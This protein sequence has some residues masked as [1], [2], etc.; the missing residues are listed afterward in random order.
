[1]LNELGLGWD[2]ACDD[3]TSI[4]LGFLIFFAGDP[5]EP[6]RLDHDIAAPMLAL[7]IHGTLDAHLGEGTQSTIV[8]ALTAGLDAIGCRTGELTWRVWRI[9]QGY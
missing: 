4:G 3:G 7:H 8:P 2:L 9:D 1:M 5:L 6:G